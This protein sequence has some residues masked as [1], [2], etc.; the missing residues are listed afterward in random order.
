MNNLSLSKNENGIT[1]VGPSILFQPSPDSHRFYVDF[2]FAA[3]LLEGLP[4]VG[5]AFTLSNK[6]G[7]AMWAHGK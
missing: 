6:I 1:D 4:V 5:L 7:A 2:G 3:A